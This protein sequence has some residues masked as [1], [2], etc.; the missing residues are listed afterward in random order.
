MQ[1]HSAKIWAFWLI[2]VKMHLF[3]GRRPGINYTFPCQCWKKVIL[4]CLLLFE[5]DPSKFQSGCWWGHKMIFKYFSAPLSLDIPT[6]ISIFE[7][8]KIILNALYT[9]GYVYYLRY[10]L[11]TYYI[12]T[13][14]Q[15]S[16]ARSFSQSEL[17]TDEKKAIAYRNMYFYLKASINFMI[18]T[19]FY[20]FLPCIK[21]IT[22]RIYMNTLV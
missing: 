13:K 16:S 9:S 14:V 15:N 10:F 21:K 2:H 1:K 4:I 22:H 8:C 12:C 18:F 20:C 5:M 6:Y 19:I 7:V 17:W 11:I 3:L